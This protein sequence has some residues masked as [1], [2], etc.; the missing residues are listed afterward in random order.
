[1]AIEDGYRQRKKPTAEYPL[2]ETI[3]FV[4]MD[5]KE[6][7]SLTPTPWQFLKEFTDARIALGRVGQGLPT[8]EWLAFSMAHAQAKDAVEL[9]LDRSLIKKDL[10]LWFEEIIEVE[11][12]ANNREEYLRRP[13]LGRLLMDEDLDKLRKHALKTKEL[14]IVVADGLSAKAIEANVVP[15]LKEFIPLAQNAGL[16]VGPIVLV[17]QARVAISDE[18]GHALGASVSIILIGERPGLS[19]PDSMGIYMTYGPK[20]GNTDEKRN[21]I[22]NIR[23]RGLPLSFAAQKLLFLV[24]QSLRLQ[25]SGVGLKDDFDMKNLE[26]LP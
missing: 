19:S 5:S 7:S 17:S 2:S 24:Q 21:C 20:P 8:A 15:F 25:L 22:S 13:D 10:S 16:Q 26:Q 3:G 14:C 12:Q 1:M 4:K 18:I 11:S 6:E 23:S 9:D